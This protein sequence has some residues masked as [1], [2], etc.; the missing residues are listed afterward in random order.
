MPGEPSPIVTYAGEILGGSSVFDWDLRAG[1]KPVDKVYTLTQSRAAKLQDKVGTPQTLRI[2]RENMVLEIQQVYLV[3]VGPGA[4]PFSSTIR[5][6]DRRWL[7]ARKHLAITFNLRRAIGDVFLLNTDGDISNAVPQP[8]IKYA[9]YT[10]DG[11]KPYT[12]RRALAKVMQELGQKHIFEDK[13]PEVEIENLVL[14]DAGD[15]GV[16]RVLAYM[17]GMAVYINRKGE[18]V[19]YDKLSGK[20][21]TILDQVARTQRVGLQVGTVDRSGVRPT[22]VRGLFTPW[23]ELRLDYEEPTSSASFKTFVQDEFLDSNTLINVA[24]SPDVELVLKDGRKVARGTWV[25]LQDLFDAWGVRQT[26]GGAQ[27]VSFKAIRKMIM[28]IGPLN[29]AMQFGNPSNT[30]PDP[31]WTARAA[32]VMAHWRR[33][34]RIA[35]TFWQRI[36]SIMPIRASILNTETGAYG[37][38]EAYCNWTRKP[39][40]W[41]LAKKRAEPNT[42]QGWFVEGYAANLSAA[43]PVPATVSIEDAQ[44]GVI[45]VEPKF[46]PYGLTDQMVFGRPTNDTIPSVDLGKSNGSGAVEFGRWGLIVLQPSWK[47]SVLLTVVPGSPN[48]SQ[49]LHAEEQVGR[50]PLGSRAATGPVQDTRIRS[51][52]MP[53]LYKWQDSRS[54]R[55]VDAIRGRGTLPVELCTNRNTLRKLTKAAADRVYE[56]L[57]DRPFGSVTVD[58][59]PALEPTGSM[60]SVRHLMQNGATVTRADFPAIRQAADIWRYLDGSTRRAVLHVLN[61]GV[62]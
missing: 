20:E 26:K 57:S 3:E 50:I 9:K 34:F 37:P 16:E 12:A 56:T 19:F 47:L 18:A 17:P 53:A 2:E 44:S 28:G 42:Q 40:M 33:T 21:K 60:E 31:V 32:T 45:R 58:M 36:A 30:I 7:W 55:I 27:P 39:S 15:N 14:D 22:K 11:N 24:P 35:D 23:M 8:K 41:G 61:N 46:D 62:A 43:H 13:P 49:R 59:A 52:V 48:T 54:G 5:L 1:T 29:F 6:V 4:D 10:I 25:P 51:G 38:A